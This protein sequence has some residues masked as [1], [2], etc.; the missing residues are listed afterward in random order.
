MILNN[1]LTFIHH[2]PHFD[3][4]LYIPSPNQ[5][6]LHLRMN[7]IITQRTLKGLSDYQLVTSYR[8]FVF[9][10]N[11]EIKLIT[12]LNREKFKRIQDA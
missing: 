4:P 11:A 12:D 6:S 7:A 5:C 3:V 2:S 1:S 10:K 8:K 9:F